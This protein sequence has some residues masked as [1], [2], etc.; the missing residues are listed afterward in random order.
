MKITKPGLYP[1]VSDDTYHSDPVPDGSLSSTFAR[2]LTEHVPAKA[3]ALRRD[4]KPTKAMNLGKA[5]HR[6]AL[7]A[8]PELIVW[9]HDGRT[10]AGKAER[11]AYADQIA[12]EV[13][14]AVSEDERDQIIGMAE[15]LRAHPYVAAVLN[16]ADAEVSGFWQEGGVWMRARYDTLDTSRAHDYKTCQDASRRGF[17]KAMAR[18][19]YHQQAEFYQRGLTALGHPAA[20][21]PMRFICQ[22]VTAPY[23]V[24][25]HT[26]DAE[27]IE[28]ARQLNDRAIRIYAESVASGTW[29][30]YPELIAEPSPLPAFYYFEHDDVLPDAWRALDDMEV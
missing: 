25:V 1:D 26:P 5:A 29:G 16:D 15:A 10:K 17:S 14:V 28:L 7:G 19:G 3:F 9:Q 8:G 30:G 21:Q 6:H 12:A 4:R 13:V 11:A 20:A 18:F 24:Q 23:L 22:E 2:L 27:A